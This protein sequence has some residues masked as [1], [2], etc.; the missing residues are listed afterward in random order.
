MLGVPWILSIGY[1]LWYFCLRC[2]KAAPQIVL[3]RVRLLYVH[4]DLEKTAHGASGTCGL[5]G[6][7]TILRTL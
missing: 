5:V 3:C 2:K 7:P 6:N 1:F 4:T